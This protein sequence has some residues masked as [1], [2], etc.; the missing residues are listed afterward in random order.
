MTFVQNFV[1]LLLFVGSLEAGSCRNNNHLKSKYRRAEVPSAVSS[2]PA[3][4]TMNADTSAP[5]RKLVCYLDFESQPETGTSIKDKSQS[6]NDGYRE[7][8]LLLVNFKGCG[9]AAYL[10]SGD[11]LFHGDTF[12]GKPYEGITIAAWVRILELPGSHSIFD[13]IGSSH[14]CGQYHFEINDGNVRWFHRNETQQTVFSVEATG[15][16]V[17]Q[18]TWVHVAGTYDGTIGKSKIYVNGD[19]KNMSVNEYGGYLSRDWN[20]RVGIGDHKNFRPVLGFVDE[21][22]VYNYAVTK[23]EVDDMVKKCNFQAGGTTTAVTPPPVPAPK[24]AV[25]GAPAPPAPPV[26]LT[27][28]AVLI[29]DDKEKETSDVKSPGQEMEETILKRSKVLRKL[30]HHKKNSH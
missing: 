28:D 7:K 23:K 26:S 25:V 29:N 11:I 12:Q 8:G 27:H 2:P 14:E 1:L 17:K 16:P 19:L 20:M 30:R 15:A 6:G 21:F 10:Y 5:T 4:T 3:T 13:T 22:R 24:P 9:N 18:A